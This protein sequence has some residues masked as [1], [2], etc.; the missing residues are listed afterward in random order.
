MKFSNS[1][2]AFVRSC[3]FFALI[4]EKNILISDSSKTAGEQGRSYDVNRRAA[5]AVLMGRS[6][7]SLM[8]FCAAFDMPPPLRDSWDSHIAKIDDALTGVRPEII[9]RFTAIK[10]CN[11]Y[12]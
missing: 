3:T 4:A 12:H 11:N 8:K 9:V 7:Q 10:E 5:A 1:A 2:R 6:R